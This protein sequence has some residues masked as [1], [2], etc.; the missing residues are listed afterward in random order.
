[1][2]LL[3]SQAVLVVLAALMGGVA[4]ASF[5]PFSITW[6]SL[7]P[8]F[9]T[10]WVWERV[11]AKRAF[12]FGLAVNF[13]VLSIAGYWLYLAPTRL[14]DIETDFGYLLTA[15][16]LLQLSLYMGMSGY[17]YARLRR[18]LP[19]VF[20]VGIFFP[21]S[22]LAAEW[23]RGS[24]L[25]GFPWFTLG[26]SQVEGVL[27]GWFPVLG[28]Y[29]VSLLLIATSAAIYLALFCRYYLAIILISMVW[30]LGYGLHMQSWT[31][32]VG[33][34]VK[35]ALVQDNKLKAGSLKPEQWR[36][37]KAQTLGL[38]DEVDLVVWSETVITASVVPL[39]Q[40]QAFPSVPLPVGKSAGDI[41]VTKT[42]HMDAGLVE[43]EAAFARHEEEQLFADLQSESERRHKAVLIGTLLRDPQRNTANNSIVALDES[44][45]SLYDKRHRVP[46]GEVYP[47]RD[48]LSEFW[49]WLSVYEDSI[50]EP[51]G[52]TPLM[53]VLG[54]PL[55]AF[56]CYE[57]GFGEEVIEALPQARF[58]VMNGNDKMFD[59]TW[60][61]EQHLQV[62]KARAL[63]TSR[64]VLRAGTSGITALI[65]PDG[66]ESARLLPH[67]FAVLT[68]E[69]PQLQGVTPYAR[70]GNLPVLVFV[71]GVFAYAM[72]LLVCRGA[73]PERES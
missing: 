54:T 24:M 61:N 70:W 18:H 30:V 69:V 1:M 44:G 47:L 68:G 28:V 59:Q 56:I 51:R 8:P 6:L 41:W 65:G 45:R 27:A 10:L 17:L 66:Q 53:Q 37:A 9:V 71:C 67:R 62:V 43:G 57:S 2:P 64:W 33:K 4:A 21:A 12:L 63:E 49:E 19:V 42:L 3:H 31:S 7:L 15:L 55:G 36:F 25:T 40:G 23:L 35:V 29:G 5:A 50:D 16:V 48:T 72:I 34:P 26:Y 13:S 58:L 20:R 14:G 60:Q 32:P 46:F 38:W 39:P 22:W 73:R 52:K 11:S